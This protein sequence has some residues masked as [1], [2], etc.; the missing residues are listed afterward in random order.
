MSLICCGCT[1]SSV[2]TFKQKNWCDAWYVGSE[3]YF[4]I[5]I[6]FVFNLLVFSLLRETNNNITMQVKSWVKKTCA[7]YNIITFGISPYWLQW[8]H[9]LHLAW[10]KNGVQVSNTREGKTAPSLNIPTTVFL[11]VFEPLW[12][13]VQNLLKRYTH[14]YT[15]LI[16]IH[17]SIRKTVFKKGK[18]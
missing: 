13:H 2:F 8:Q 3:G 1:V 17:I 15:S 10:R 12:Y 9:A 16:K 6:A 7:F 14:T 4:C 18:S 5:C 11:C